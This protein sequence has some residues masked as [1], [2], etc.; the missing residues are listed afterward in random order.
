MSTD[1]TIDYAA[2]LADLEARRN[3]LDAAIAAVRLIAGQ[4]PLP[5]VVAPS[6]QPKLDVHEIPTDAFH[7][8]SI[9]DATRKYLA[10]VR[11]KQSTR[12]IAE[13]LETGGLH[14]TAKNFTTTVYTVLERQSD[15][16]R[17]GKDW[18]LASWYPGLNRG[19]KVKRTKPEPA[20]PAKKPTGKR[21]GRPPKAKHRHPL[22]DVAEASAEEMENRDRGEPKASAA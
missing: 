22:A 7:G 20:T 2:V 9:A 16:V 1:T 21:R 5:T 17:V 3:A 4:A 6:D 10:A 11:R 19:A 13:A 14:S 8:M 18:G 15:I 12:Q